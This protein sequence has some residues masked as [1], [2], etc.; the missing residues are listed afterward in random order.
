VAALSP[1]IVLG[2][3]IT[4]V[5]PVA[6][7]AFGLAK[8]GIREVDE[9]MVLW[10]PDMPF[11]E[12]RCEPSPADC[13]PAKAAAPVAS[14]NA[15][16]SISVFFIKLPFTN[17]N[18]IMVQQRF[19]LSDVTAIAL[20][21]LIVLAKEKIPL[22]I[23]Q[24]TLKLFLSLFARSN[25]INGDRLMHDRDQRSSHVGLR[26]PVSRRAPE[27]TQRG[28]LNRSDENVSTPMAT[29]ERKM[30]DAADIPV[31]TEGLVRFDT[32]ARP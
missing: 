1:A 30:P 11:I 27:T 15:A 16:A 32:A 31:G 14:D 12:R 17:D 25:R 13:E 29:I 19:C 26:R 22:T 3:P 4:T 7:G 8:L 28:F 18:T 9:L 2:S 23:K 10:L 24:K 5:R 21:L 20:S 6:P